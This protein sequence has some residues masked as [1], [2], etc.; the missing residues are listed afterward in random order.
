MMLLG[1]RLAPTHGS[2]VGTKE[3]RIPSSEFFSSETGRYRALIFGFKHLPVDIY[4]VC[5]Y[6]A[7]EVKTGLTPGSQVGTKEQR[8][9]TSKVFFSETGRIRALIFGIYHLFVDLYQFYSYDFFGV[10]PDPTP[11]VTN[12]T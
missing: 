4:Q 5:S 6:D 8:K 3:R 7:R 9:P 2:Q 11:G 10:K 12:G 1:S